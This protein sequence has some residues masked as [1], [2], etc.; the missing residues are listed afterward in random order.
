MQRTENRNKKEM[1][2][3]IK[4]KTIKIIMTNYRKEWEEEGTH[5]YES[6][7]DEKEY[8]SLLASLNNQ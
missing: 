5:I 1:K 6:R 2:I 8:F 4:I 7:K 3:K